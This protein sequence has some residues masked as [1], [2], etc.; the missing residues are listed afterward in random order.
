[1]WLSTVPLSECWIDAFVVYITNASILLVK[2]IK[3]LSVQLVLNRLL[4]TVLIL[5]INVVELHWNSFMI[6]AYWASPTISMIPRS[7]SKIVYVNCFSFSF[8][9]YISLFSFPYKPFLLSISSVLR[10][11]SCLLVANSYRW[12][13]SSLLVGK[14][15]RLQY[16]SIKLMSL[17]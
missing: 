6:S 11:S 10:I 4:S 12:L 1:M 2:P 17:I 3:K 13:Y 15:S 16:L 7:Q 9:S 5:R 8:P 14:S